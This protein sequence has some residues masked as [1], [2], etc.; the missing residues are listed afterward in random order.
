[1]QYTEYMDMKKEGRRET[2]EINK[3]LYPFGMC[4]PCL[5]CGR[6]TSHVIPGSDGESFTVCPGDRTTEFNS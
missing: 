1:M 5:V 6:E 3:D 2:G 4:G